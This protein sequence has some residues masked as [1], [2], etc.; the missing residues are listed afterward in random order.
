MIATLQERMNALSTIPCHVQIHDN[1]STYLRSEKRSGLLHLFMHRFFSEAPTPV[2]EAVLR[3]AKGRDRRALQTIRQ[4]ANLYFSENKI[5]PRKFNVVGDVYNLEEILNR[6]RKTYFPPDYSPAIGW[7]GRRP[8]GKFRS[9]TFGTYDRHRHQVRIN[10][11]LDHKEVPLS[12]IEFVVYHEMLHGICLPLV[13]SLGRTRVH[14]PEF[15]AKEKLFAE[16]K[17]AKAWEKKSLV[18][19]KKERSYGRA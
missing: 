5:E 2:L 14:T 10:P 11:I 13:D 1:C 4:M 17:E 12:F 7:A 19:F 8:N 15:R 3:F 6:V 18:F 16:F 9:I